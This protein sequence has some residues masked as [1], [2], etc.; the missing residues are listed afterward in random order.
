MYFDRLRFVH[1][2]YSVCNTLFFRSTYIF[3]FFAF[4]RNV[5]FHVFIYLF[6]Y[7][8]HLISKPIFFELI[9]SR[10][11]FSH[12]CILSLFYFLPESRETQRYIEKEESIV[13]SKRKDFVC[14]F[15]GPFYADWMNSRLRFFFVCR[16]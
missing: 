16:P 12:F 6:I 9:L 7:L 5:Y 8:V 4:L 11:L 2:H 14:F 1:Y 3:F 15:F 13:Y 10:Y